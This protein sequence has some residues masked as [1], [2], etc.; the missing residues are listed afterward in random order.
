MVSHLQILLKVA[1]S[2]LATSGSSGELPLLPLRGSKSLEAK[3][4]YSSF[5]PSLFL[6]AQRIPFL[7]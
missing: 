7:A 6:F 4:A 2:R 3:A 5:V 1:Y